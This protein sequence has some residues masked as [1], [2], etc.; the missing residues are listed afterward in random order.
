MYCYVVV[1]FLCIL[2]YFGVLWCILVYSYVF[3]VCLCL[4]CTLAYSAVILVYFQ[5]VVHVYVFCVFSVI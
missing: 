5:Y 1:V 3:Y 4:L 2:M